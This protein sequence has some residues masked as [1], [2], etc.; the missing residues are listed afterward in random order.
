MPTETDHSTT[1]AMRP[2]GLAKICPECPKVF[3]GAGW[4]GIDAHWKA[5]HEKV[6]PY[7]KAWPM[8]K[9]GNYKTGR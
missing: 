4:T 8:L 3:Q 7:A 9:A 1:S 6:M 2:K 5:E